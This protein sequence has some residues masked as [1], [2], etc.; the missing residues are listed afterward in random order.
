MSGLEIPFSGKPS[1]D[2]V[3]ATQARTTACKADR[4][5][6]QASH[7]SF[8]Y[9]C[10]IVECGWWAVVRLA[11]SLIAADVILPIST[12]VLSLPSCPTAF[13]LS[14]AVPTTFRQAATE[15][16]YQP[17]SVGVEEL[18][19]EGFG[20]HVGIFRSWLAQVREGELLGRHLFDRVLVHRGL[21]LPEESHPEPLAEVLH[22][23]MTQTSETSKTRT[24][25]TY[26][27]HTQH[28]EDH[29][30]RH[31]VSEGIVI[32]PRYDLKAEHDQQGPHGAHA[33]G[34]VILR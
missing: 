10:R 1:C 5:Q 18:V 3:L 4:H 19:L 26:P 7:V 20:R 8:H 13:A 15:L 29:K 32:V 24:F 2:R 23:L 22:D 27:N 30:G 17:G 21:D 34:K 12:L 9:L 16:F 11:R 33:Y 31:L 25:K 6:G 28:N 14:I